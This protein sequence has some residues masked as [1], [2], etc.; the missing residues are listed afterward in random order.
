MNYGKKG[1]RAK[2]QAVSSKGGKWGRKIALIILKLSNLGRFLLFTKIES[3]VLNICLS[4]LLYCA[5][6]DLVV[7]KVLTN[8]IAQITEKVPVIIK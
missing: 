2:Q 5:S 1:I 8:T 7:I 4:L 6:S 3:Y